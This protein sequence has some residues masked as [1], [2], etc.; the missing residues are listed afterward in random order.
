MDLESIVHQI[1][2][3]TN[4]AILIADADVTDGAVLTIRW[5]NPSFSRLTFYASEDVYGQTMGMLAG[6]RTDLAT[7][8]KI[9]DRLM[10]WE[11]F[12][13]DIYCH[14][15]D[16]TGFWGHFSF[17]PLKDKT[18]DYRFWVS[19]IRDVT[20]RRQA[21]E[22]SRDLALIA[23]HTGDMVALHDADRQVEWVN[24]SF[25]AFTGYSIEEAAG[26]RLGALLRAPEGDSEQAMRA[27]E[28][29]AALDRSEPAVGELLSR[30][31]DGTLFLGQYDMQPVF[32]E[33]GRL[34]RFVSLIRDITERRSLEMRYKAVFDHSNAAIAIKE[35]DR[36]LMV[37]RA[38]AEPFGRN[39]DWFQGRRARDVLAAQVYDATRQVEERVLADGRPVTWERSGQRHDGSPG[40]FMAR[41]FSVFDPVL[42]TTL[43]CTVETDITQLHDQQRQLETYAAELRSSQ[44][45]LE[46][47]N[48]ELVS[49]S[50]QLEHASMHD[51]LTG[52]PNRRYLDSKLREMRARLTTGGVLSVLHIDLDRFKQI[53]DAFGH[54]AGDYVLRQV[55]RTL[56]AETRDGD[57]AA[58]VG[59][60]EFV[61][62]SEMDGD[63]D[64]VT[65]FA[66]R[67]IRKLST[68]QRFEGHECR[69]G[70]S[71]GIATGRGEGIDPAQLLINADIAL[72][73]AKAAGRNRWA[74][75]SDALQ[76]EVVRAKSI[77]DDILRGLD[78]DE[79]FALYQPQ[80]NLDD[81][82]LAGAEV[83]M[84]WNHPYRGEL[85]PA[86]FIRQ[87]SDLNVLAQIDQIILRKAV[88]DDAL[89]RASGATIDRISINVSGRRLRDPE[90]VEDIR[91]CGIDPHR[92]SVE[93]LESIF[94]DDDEEMLVWAIDQ[95]KEMGVGIE[96]DDFGTGHSSIVG[97]IRL[98]PDRLK[99]DRQFID[100]AMATEE[101]REIV[102]SVTGIGHSLGVEVLAEGVET[103]AQ[104]SLLRDVGCN[105]V[106]GYAFGPPMSADEF[107]DFLRSPEPRNIPGRA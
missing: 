14:R 61:I 73:R 32:D 90:L 63:Q 24:P 2:K 71:I 36:F 91:T 38:F 60:D 41:T 16:G 15:K 87:A 44:N 66:S 5:V 3:F 6:A 27:N 39:V 57:F 53:N 9:I 92:L 100:Q 80:F 54:A 55:A 75:F 51:T 12:S 35:K 81:M 64:Q 65:R 79:F 10:C 26:K 98:K 43:I 1:G 29:T 86:D 42:N 104:L 11:H 76:A 21:E 68:P 78:R 85:Q 28:L 103:E 47:Q 30:R 20:V 93:L 106:Q 74:L 77:S 102:R 23:E 37:N 97:L 46:Q 17:Q 83:L 107:R 96:L 19:L 7:L 88:K 13:E 31:K 95:L 84:R 49:I 45:A 22:R 8:G 70:A 94:V 48:R 50:E 33:H 89:W 56:L 72:Y 58:R 69:F 105:I 40:E 67:I 62:L 18:G 59:G 101:Y 4:E 25:T 52:L 99:I 82:S 34:S